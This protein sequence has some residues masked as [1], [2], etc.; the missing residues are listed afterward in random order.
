[1]PGSSCG[2]CGQEENCGSSKEHS[3]SPSSEQE[4]CDKNVDKIT[5]EKSVESG[6]CKSS[7][8]GNDSPSNEQE[9][10]DKSV[11]KI[12]PDKIVE[13]GNYESS[14]EGND[15][16]SNQQE[17]CDQNVHVDNITPGSEEGVQ[18]QRCENS[19]ECSDSQQQVY[20]NNFPAIT[21]EDTV[22][23]EGFEKTTQ[24]TGSQ[25]QDPEHLDVISEDVSTTKLSATESVDIERCETITDLDGSSNCDINSKMSQNGNMSSHCSKHSEDKNDDCKLSFS[26]EKNS[27]K[28][29]QHISS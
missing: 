15:S 26:Q 8:E 5:P 16:P 4:V 12:I 9:L 19:T 14:T 21:D 24:H 28:Y 13:S 22:E 25:S 23:K 29:K 10:C 6:N 2:K 3:V 18:S 27:E 7:T 1:M 17:L 11:D 20:E